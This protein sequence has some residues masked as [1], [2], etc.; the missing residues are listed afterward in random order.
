VIGDTGNDRVRRV[1]P[2]GNI[3]TI[4]GAIRGL[5]GDDGPATDAQLSAPEGVAV[6]AD[7]SILIADTDNGR[8]RWV[9]PDGTITTI[10]GAPGQ[11]LTSSVRGCTIRSAWPAPPTVVA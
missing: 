11:P 9:A 2:E 10:A 7:G 4:A 8:V 6:A 5:S 1:S 3:T